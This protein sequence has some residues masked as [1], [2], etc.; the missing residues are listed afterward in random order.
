MMFYG[1]GYRDCCWKYCGSGEVS[2]VEL[3]LTSSVRMVEKADG[4]QDWRLT[5]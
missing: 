4:L 3:A 2:A 5:S 1:H